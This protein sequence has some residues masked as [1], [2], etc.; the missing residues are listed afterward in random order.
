[1]PSAN[2]VVGADYTSSLYGLPREPCNIAVDSNE[3]VY[4]VKWPSGVTEYPASQFNTS[5]VAASGTQVDPVGSTLSV[6]HSTNE[7]FIDQQSAVAEFDSSL[8]PVLDFGGEGLI[9]NSFGIAANGA[10]ANEIVYVANGTSVDIFGP[11]VVLVSPSVDDQPPSVS[12]IERTSVLLSGTVNPNG[13]ETEYHFVYGTSEAY[14]SNTPVLSAGKGNADVTVGPV[15]VSGL[16]PETTYHYALVATSLGGT[17]TGSDHT[18]T[19]APRTPPLVNGQLPSVSD[20]GRTSAVVTG[21]VNPRGL[22]TTY[23]FAYGTS[24]ARESSTPTQSVGEGDVDVAAGPVGIGALQP[25]TTYHYALV[26]T[27]V[28]GTVTGPDQTFTTGRRTPPTAITGA[29]SGVS[30]TSATLSGA[31]DPSDLQTSYEFEIGESAAY[32]GSQ[33]FGNAGDAGSEELVSATLAYLVPGTTYHYRL[34]ATSVDGVI[35]GADQTFTTPGVVSPISQPLA[36]PLLTFESVTFPS[37]K[38]SKVVVQKKRKATKK[39]RKAKH[40][41]KK[42]S[43]GS[44]H[45]KKS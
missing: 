17:V 6:D 44:E 1:M 30:S 14:G 33:I 4:E 20:I 32:G 28:D 2:P 16:Q 38:T 35:Y 15:S 45:K 10:G 3:N 8:D 22:Q 5:E 18:F 42:V 43:R 41:K 19:T 37:E 39:K 12:E 13:F 7:I 23:H 29:A 11:A 9:N 40:G 34:V 36:T 26:A 27:N 25:E 24:E 21:T 31:V